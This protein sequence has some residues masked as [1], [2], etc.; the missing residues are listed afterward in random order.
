MVTIKQIA[1]MCGVSRGTVDRVL[2]Q[3][4]NVK[5]EKSRL[6]ME[7]AKKLNYKPNPAGKALVSRRNRPVVGI[8]LPAK[9][10]SFFDEVIMAMRLSEKKYGLFGLKSEWRIM[11]GYDVGKLCA[12]MDELKPSVNA[13]ILNPIN[14][15]RVRRKIDQFIDDGIFVVAVNNDIE[16]VKAHQYVGSDYFNGGQTAA[17][18]LKMICPAGA[19]IGIT[20]GSRSV[21][22]H[23]QR[24]QGFRA[25]LKG[26][27]RFSVLMTEEDRDDDIYAF[28]RT[29][30]MLKAHPEISAMFLAASGGAYGVCRA[31]ISQKRD[32]D[33]T[34]IAFDTIPAIVEMMQKGVVNAAIY[35]HPR[36]QGEKA[37]QIVFDYLVN[38]IKPDH[39]LHIMKND[40]RILQNV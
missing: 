6:I 20:I 19:K 40:I 15:E 23:K 33:I 38:G 13:L 7:M 31:I 8:L 1:D 11:D 14:D 9:G 2:N 12:I 25:L 28:E 37:M 5:P 17:A 24:E 18:L 30:A 10:I 39:D 36:Q 22:G 21:L 32:Q 34:V 27:D 3:R 35:Q 26:D 16:G 29:T 4:G